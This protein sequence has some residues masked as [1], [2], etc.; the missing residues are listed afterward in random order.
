MSINVK[1]NENILRKGE[2]SVAAKENNLGGA[3]GSAQRKAAAMA[4]ACENRQ[5]ASAWRRKPAAGWRKAQWR[6]PH[7]RL[8]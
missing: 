7:R 6:K 1:S 2:N 4:L 8:K 5:S 3:G